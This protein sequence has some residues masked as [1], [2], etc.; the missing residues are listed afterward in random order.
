MELFKEFGTLRGQPP[1]AKPA[2]EMV[3]SF[4]GLSLRISTN[5]PL[6]SSVPS[7]RPMPAAAQ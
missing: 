2:Q 6:K 5:V 1:E 3:K 4:A 7:A